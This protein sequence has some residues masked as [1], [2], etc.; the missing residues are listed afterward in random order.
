MSGGG[1]MK[2]ERGAV[3]LATLESET[4]REL[5]KDTG[6]AYR[7]A[8]EW[9]D[10]GDLLK[11]TVEAGRKGHF[12]ETRTVRQIERFQWALAPALLCLILSFWR[13]FPVRPKPREMKL[14][15][16]PA[17]ALL[18]FALFSAS[19]AFGCRDAA[20]PPAPAP[21]ALPRPDRRPAFH[22]GVSP[23]ARLGRA[24]A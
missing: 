13:E 4:L 18:V 19:S 23:G 15:A 9:V 8:G 2:D 24:G 11:S 21:S 20:G 1:F 17:L 7:D 5:A 14:G 10:L 16:G 12:V 22:R 3:V 6:G